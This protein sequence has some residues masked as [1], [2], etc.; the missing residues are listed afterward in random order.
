MM[1]KKHVDM[2]RNNSW[3]QPFRGQ[4]AYS[5]VAP[6]E[7]M[8]NN[9]WRDNNTVGGMLFDDEGLSDAGKLKV[10]QVLAVA[11]PNRRILFVQA[12]ASPQ[13]TAARV[14]SVQ[15]AVSEQVPEGQL[16]EILVTNKAPTSSPGSYQTVVHRAMQRTTPTP[17]LPR[18][19]GLSQPG[20]TTVAPQGAG[21]GK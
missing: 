7:A 6:F 13:E 20:Q 12:G 18:Y 15:M 5:V 1:H 19:S 16:P 21:G 4:D 11:P 10:A 9:G 3:P 17:R 8:K 2:A 14:E